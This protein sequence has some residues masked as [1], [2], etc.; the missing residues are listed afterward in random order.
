MMKLTFTVFNDDDT[1][2]GYLF[3]VTRVEAQEAVTKINKETREHHY[4]MEGYME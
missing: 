3:N 1:V 2:Y 4:F